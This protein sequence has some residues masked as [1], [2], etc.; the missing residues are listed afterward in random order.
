M[1]MENLIKR[2][3]A[4]KIC[5]QTITETLDAMID[6]YNN[7][8]KLLFC[9]N[10]GSCA[11]CDHIVG[12]LMKGFLSMREADGNIKNALITAFPEDGED[13]GNKLQRGIPAISLSAHTGVL[14]AFANDVD[15][16]LIYA[17]MVYGYGKSGDMVIGLS[18]SG[19]SKNVIKALKVAKAMGLKTAGLTG[20]KPCRMDDVCDIVIHVPETETYK[21]QEYHLPVYH[22]ICAEME[23][24]IFG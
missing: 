4:L 2:Y 7:G 5:R 24:R 18:T 3:P 8:G 17:Q 9:G 22:Y 11:D 14:T 1:T 15:A 19:N 21:I 10:G 20:E 12:E 23:K 6:V 13:I 16:D